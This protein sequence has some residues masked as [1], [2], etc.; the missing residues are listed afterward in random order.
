MQTQHITLLAKAQNG[1]ITVRAEILVS[2]GAETY[3]VTIAI[4]PQPPAEAANHP[5]HALD[6]LYGAL[7]DT[8]LPEI[9]ADPHPET[10][11]DM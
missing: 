2:D 4:T 8:L 6:S 1:K 10:R 7:A 11:D 3:L 9:T 5:D